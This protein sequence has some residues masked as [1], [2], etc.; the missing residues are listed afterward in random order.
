VQKERGERGV[1]QQSED[2]GVNRVESFII[3]DLNEEDR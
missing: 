3:K 2:R 1:R